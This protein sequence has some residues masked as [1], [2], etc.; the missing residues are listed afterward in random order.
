MLHVN[1]DKVIFFSHE[2]HAYPVSISEYGKLRKCAAKSDFLRCLE[3]LVAPCHEPPNVDMMIIDG[4]AFVNIN[5]PKV[6]KTFGEYCNVEK[7]RTK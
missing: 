6:S 5:Q 1:Q 3:D 4:A 7:L 2:N